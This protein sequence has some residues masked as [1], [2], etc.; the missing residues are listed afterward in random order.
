MS[1]KS[2]GAAGSSEPD[3]SVLKSA[4]ETVKREL[5][6]RGWK[7][8]PCGWEHASCPHFTMTIGSAVHKEI[9]TTNA[10]AQLPKVS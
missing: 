5:A 10:S 6:S 3:C 9:S 1:E 2:T 7:H 4:Y 8:T